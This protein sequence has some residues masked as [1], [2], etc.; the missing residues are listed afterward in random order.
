[1]IF[2]AE[3]KIRYSRQLSLPAV[4]YEGQ[5]QLKN[6][7]VL[8]I[9][10]GGLGSSALPYLAAAGVG[11]IGIVDDDVVELSNLQ[12]QILYS[13]IELGQKKVYAAQNKLLALNSD[14]HVIAHDEKLHVN[15]ALSL[16]NQYNIVLDCTDNFAARY[17]INDA[18]FHLKKPNVSA[19]IFQ[20]DGQCSVF[21]TNEGPCYRCLYPIPPPKDLIPD[22]AQ[23]GVLGVMAG[24]LGVMQATEA[25]KLILNIGQTLVGRLL[26]VN[27]LNWQ[28]NEYTL[29]RN[30]DCILCYHH[31]PFLTLPRYQENYC[32]QTKIVEE[33]TVKEV[34]ALRDQGA[35]FLI[36]DVRE[37][38]E[39]EAANIGGKLIPIGQL[40]ERV[41]ELNSEQLI[42]VHCKSGGRSRRAVEFLMEA[43][44]SNVKNLKGGITAWHAEVA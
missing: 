27:V 25:I 33:I 19:S 14:I 17:L 12:R 13:S 7:R 38:A 9:G 20:F 28:F 42:I 24:L 41:N 16:I 6:A 43:G 44:F 29:T 39:Y 35:D 21:T 22:C 18:A 11:T 3:E 5:Q 1:M 4:G 26:T 37:P 30:P 15:N 8:C 10:A 40:P 36:L 34:A 23:G 2:N 31:Q 32:M